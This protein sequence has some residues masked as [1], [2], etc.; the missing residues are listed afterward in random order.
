MKISTTIITFNEE[1]NIER[2]IKSVKAFSDEIIVVDSGS[3]DS[4]VKLATKLG[5]K[6]YVRKFDNFANQKNFAISKTHGEWIFS[7]DADEV[8]TD[9]LGSE[10]VQ[11]IKSG[12][13][14]AY[15]IP[16]KN[17]ILGA[18]IKYSRWQP[19]LDRHVWL[20]RKNKSKWVGNVHEEITVKGKI[21][22]INSC[23]EHYQDKTI[24]DFLNKLNRYSEIESDILY[25][26]K[27]KF[28]FL[29][30]IVQTKYNF[31]VRYIYRLGFL[32][33]WRGFVLSCL[34][35]FYHFQIWIKLWQKQ[36]NL[37]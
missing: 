3:S 13:Y 10:I 30:L 22:K 11:S 37:D 19:E 14:N 32:D 23:K 12:K 33:G 6:V 31:L 5:A 24:K 29:K 18:F 35:A 4:T 26:N 2:C 25:K 34:M 21:G 36:Q 27:I 16:R 17:H 8:V 9:E 20:F 28:S 15:S 7:I 1:E